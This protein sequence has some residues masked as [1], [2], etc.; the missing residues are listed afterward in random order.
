MKRKQSVRALIVT[1]LPLF[2]CSL[3]SLLQHES[4]WSLLNRA[5]SRCGWITYMKDLEQQFLEADSMAVDQDFCLFLYQW[6]GL[7]SKFGSL[8]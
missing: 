3:F 2:E 8:S 5:L 7:K 1:G 4:F 6:D